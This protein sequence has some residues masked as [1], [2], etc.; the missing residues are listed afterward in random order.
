MTS[1]VATDPTLWSAD[2]VGAWFE[3]I[4]CGEYKPLVEKEDLDGQLLFLLGDT[5]LHDFGILNSFHRK[6][7]LKKKDELAG[8]KESNNAEP[9]PS[10]RPEREVDLDEGTRIAVAVG[11]DTMEEKELMHGAVGRS[12]PKDILSRTWNAWPLQSTKTIAWSNT[13]SLI[14]KPGNNLQEFVDSKWP[15]D[16]ALMKYSK[17]HEHEEI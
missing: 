8:L 5:E 7:I 9:I 16:S 2:D 15:S 17:N 11:A 4:G 12:G 1:F 6:K 3:S 14:A 13:R 10:S